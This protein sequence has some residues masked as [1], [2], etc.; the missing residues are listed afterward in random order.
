MLRSE[1]SP[2]ARQRLWEKVARVV[3]G[4]ANVRTRQ[5]R[6]R[7]EWLRVWEWVG[8]S[9]GTPGI[10]RRQSMV[11]LNGASG[12]EGRGSGRKSIMGELAAQASPSLSRL[13]RS[14]LG[15]AGGAAADAD[16]STG[17]PLRREAEPQ[18]EA[19]TSRTRPA[20]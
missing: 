20:F 17:S 4:N 8:V 1:H 2:A 15:A 9:A 14:L 6:S 19:D 16:T 3:E 11:D 18:M 13:G 10:S 7:G 12:S 5:A